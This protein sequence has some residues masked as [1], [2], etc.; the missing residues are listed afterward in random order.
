M[1]GVPLVQFLRVAD[2]A[3][4]MQVVPL[5]RLLWELRLRASMFDARIGLFANRALAVAATT[6]VHIE[7]RFEHI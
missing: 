6:V 4:E 7:E 2:L 5:E 3:N 1:I